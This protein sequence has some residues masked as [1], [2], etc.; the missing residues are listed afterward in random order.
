MSTR[1]QQ[2]ASLLSSGATQYRK[3]HGYDWNY[4]GGT[5]RRESKGYFVQVGGVSHYLGSFTNAVN[6]FMD[7]IVTG[8]PN[9]AMRR[10]GR[11]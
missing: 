4:L 8:K 3:K 1:T 11:Q 9:A 7:Y 10:A 6:H 2:L 5:I